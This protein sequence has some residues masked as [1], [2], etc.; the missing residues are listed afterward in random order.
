MN[1]FDWALVGG[2]GF[3]ALLAMASYLTALSYRMRIQ[4]HH[5]SLDDYSP[6]R[7]ILIGLGQDIDRKPKIT[8]SQ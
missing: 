7:Q 8:A 1:G 4:K 5:L 2:M 3:G 6:A